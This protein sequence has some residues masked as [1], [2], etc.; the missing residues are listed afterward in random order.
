MDRPPPSALF[1][2]ERNPQAE[3][4]RTRA[5]YSITTAVSSKTAAAASG[6]RLIGNKSLKASRP[7][8]SCSL[9][10]RLHMK[11]S[12]MSGYVSGKRFVAGGAPAHQPLENNST[13][14]TPVGSSPV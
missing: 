8:A 12:L 1:H 6:P 5:S 11:D 7:S 9:V 10:A 13:D 3:R 2:V 4:G 14:P